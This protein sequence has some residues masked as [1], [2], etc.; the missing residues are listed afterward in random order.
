[1]AFEIAEPRADSEA[2]RQLRRQRL[3]DRDQ[4]ERRARRRGHARDHNVVGRVVDADGEPAARASG[5]L[6]IGP[7]FPALGGVAG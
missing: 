3:G 5:I 7:A 2:F 1:M 6:K 4:L